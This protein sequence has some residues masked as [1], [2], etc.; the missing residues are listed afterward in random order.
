MILLKMSQI[1]AEPV[2][3]KIPAS[4]HIRLR[5]E[6]HQA[7]Q[8][9]QTALNREESLKLRRIARIPVMSKRDR[10]HLKHLNEHKKVMHQEGAFYRT[11]YE[12]ADI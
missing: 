10:Q 11:G 8:F 9:L 12:A 3:M 5:A 6:T 4:L 1:T 2:L 7:G